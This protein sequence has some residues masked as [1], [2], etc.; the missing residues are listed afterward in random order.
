MKL[1]GQDITQLNV[2]HYR[3]Q[4]ALVSQEPVSDNTFAASLP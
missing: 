4:V 2:Q 3:Q 1:D